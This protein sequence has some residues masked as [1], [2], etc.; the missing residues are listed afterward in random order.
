MLDLKS[1]ADGQAMSAAGTR[2]VLTPGVARRA[3]RLA[4]EYIQANLAE[5]VCLADIARAASLSTFHFARVFRNATG[6]TP[7][8][9]CLQARVERVKGLLL[10]SEDGLAAVAI[11]AG[12]SDQSHMSNVFRR[13]TGMTPRAFRN[14][15]IVRIAYGSPDLT[16]PLRSEPPQ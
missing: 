1:E 6:V 11:Q 14:T 10:E 15:S 8:R 16:H 12:F 2:V 7:Y 4:I 3:V 13:L 5:E 9:Y